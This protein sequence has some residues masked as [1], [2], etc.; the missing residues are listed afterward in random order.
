[1]SGALRIQSFNREEPLPGI[2]V[3]SQDI[4][5]CCVRDLFLHVGNI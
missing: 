5:S 1:M 4:L 2:N 3:S